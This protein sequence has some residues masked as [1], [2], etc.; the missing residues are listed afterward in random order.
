MI[1]KGA[2][3]CGDVGGDCFTEF[4]TFIIVEILGAVVFVFPVLCVQ[5]TISRIP[6]LPS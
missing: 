2:D 1:K 4:R 5:V 3:V 6:H